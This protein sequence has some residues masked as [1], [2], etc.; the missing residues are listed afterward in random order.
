M[1]EDQDMGWNGHRGAAPDPWRRMASLVLTTNE[2]LHRPLPRKGNGLPV[3]VPRGSPGR[4]VELARYN[5]VQYCF[6]TE[7]KEAIYSIAS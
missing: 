4:P 3:P 1:T 6:R 5:G 7:M 2:E